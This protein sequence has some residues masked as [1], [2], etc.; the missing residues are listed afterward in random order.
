MINI[1][2]TRDGDFFARLLVGSFLAFFLAVKAHAQ[3]YDPIPT[4]YCAIGF[5]GSPSYTALENQVTS[6]N[7]EGKFLAQFVLEAFAQANA[8]NGLLDSASET[9]AVTALNRLQAMWVPASQNFKWNYAD[10]GVTDTNAVEF[11]TEY[12]VQIPYRFPKLLA[13]YGPVSQSGTIENLLATVLSEGQIGELNHNIAVSY[14]NIWLSRVCNLILTG[15]GPADGSGN[16]L[17]TANSIVLNTGRTDLMSWISTVRNYGVHEFLSPTY[18]G[19]DLEVLGYIYLFSTDPGISAMAQQGA[20]LL[21][22]DLYANWYTQDQR[23]GGT[24]SRTY[25]FLTDEDRETDRFLYAV[26][27]LTNP[28]SPQW[29]LLLTNRTTSSYWRGQDFVAYVLPPTNDVP[30]L[31]G[32]QIAAN[33]S[34]TILRSFIDPATD[35]NTNFLYGENYM[36]NPTGTGGLYYPFSVG[37]TESFYDSPQFEGLTIML[38]GSGNTVNVNF[39]M[40]G[41]ENYYLQGSAPATLSPFIASVQNAAETLFVASSNGQVDATSGATE[42]ASTIVLPNTAQVWI[43]TATTPLSLSA[44]QSVSL[45]AGSTI[46]IAVT[47]P[48]QVDTLVTG[49]RFL[50]STDMSGNSIGLSLVNDGSAYNALRITCEHTATTP[51]SGYAVV[52]F[53]TRTAYCSDTSTNFNAFRSAFTSATVSALYSAATGQVSLAVPGLNSTM[54]VQANVITETINSLSGSDLDSAFTLPLLSVNG[55]E[56]VTDT[57]QNWTSQDIG[58]ATGG[59]ATER[60]SQGLYTGQVQVVGGGTDI[61]GT[62]DGFQFYY[63]QLVGDGTV[64]A[65]LTSMPTGT[66]ISAWTKAGVMMRNDLTPGSMNALCSLDGTH[67]QRFSVRTAEN[68]TSARSGNKT[69]TQPYWFKV[70]RAGNTFTGYSSAD[71]VNWTQVGAA[72]TIPMNT[73]IYAGIAVTSN[74]ESSPITTGF[75]SLGVLQQ[76][77]QNPAL[78]PSW[79]KR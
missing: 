5:D 48:G 64:V 2:F 28:P 22:I 34:R 37:S 18:T 8:N 17:L 6:T 45:N 54:A 79:A 51:S 23:I 56:Y 15:Q 29:P 7:P 27:H 49:I 14:T 30:Y 72:T 19:V 43:G 41:L 62:A 74:N 31:Y 10:S 35:Y 55:T 76:L 24:H 32:A 47:N 57:V 25:E 16:S 36:A 78:T 20:K 4:P 70:T 42:V 9:A 38:P 44:G 75:D 71:G 26:S 61:W 58:N 1:V 63:Q 59:S 69:T 21:W 13:Q 12:L 77:S 60:S 50:V 73:T 53:W 68:G 67:G 46:F 66:G 11:I 52:G 39:N 3:T 40:Q 65:R 33:K